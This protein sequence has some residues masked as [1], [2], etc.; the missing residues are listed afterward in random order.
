MVIIMGVSK[1]RPWITVDVNSNAAFSMEWAFILSTL[2]GRKKVEVGI[3]KGIKI[4]NNS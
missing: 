4:F 3:Y 1:Y 2:G